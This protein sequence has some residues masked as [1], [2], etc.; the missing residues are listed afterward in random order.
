MFVKYVQTPLGR[1]AVAGDEHGIS[2]LYLPRDSVPKRLIEGDTEPLNLA[3]QQLLEY[4]GGERKSFDLPLNLDCTEFQRAV[5]NQLGLIPYGETTTYGAIAQA[6]G[7]QGAARAVGQVNR[8]N[9]LPIFLPCHRVIGA[10]GKLTGFRG[11]LNMK[12][13]LLALERG[14][15]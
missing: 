12:K 7:K 9:P 13:K 10:N 6:L 3:Q 8:N 2:A 5:Y 11:G 4:F 1:M 14:E 15:S